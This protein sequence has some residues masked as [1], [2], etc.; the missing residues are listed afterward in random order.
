M[1]ALLESLVAYMCA[2]KSVDVGY[3]Q[4]IDSVSVTS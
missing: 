1:Q 2:W 4:D 3:V